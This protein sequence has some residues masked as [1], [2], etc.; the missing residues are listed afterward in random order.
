[1]RTA[2]HL[3]T[4]G[5]QEREQLLATLRQA[6][7]GGVD[8]LHIREK[9]RTARELYELLQEVASFFPLERVLLNDRVDVALA[10]GCGVHLAYHS[11]PPHAVA[12]LLP[13]GTWWG[14]SVHSLEEAETACLQGARYVYYGHIYPS[15][16]KPGVP[17]RGTT[18]LS[19]LVATLPIPVIAIGGI[20]PDNTAE[21]LATGCAGI[22]V[23][24]GISGAADPAE[25]ARA[26]R[27]K[28]E[29]I[30][31]EGTE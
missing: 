3:V 7:L 19:R 2:L 22:A 18:E 11:L 27:R 29:E 4:S 31:L 15:G 5:G 1:M 8:V 30:H 21:V 6:A 24:S 16:S 10:A 23:L 12:A 13:S 28:L 9:Q 20:T 25:A 26:Y 14:C 17:P